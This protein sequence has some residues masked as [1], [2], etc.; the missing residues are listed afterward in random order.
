MECAAA[1][2]GNNYTWCQKNLLGW[3]HWRHEDA[4]PALRLFVRRLISLQ[5]QLASLLNPDVPL[6]H[7][8]HSGVGTRRRASSRLLAHG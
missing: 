6:I 2:G 5:L 3:I 4:D 7:R 1:R 8:N